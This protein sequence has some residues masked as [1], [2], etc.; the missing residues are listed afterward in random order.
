MTISMVIFKSERKNIFST[1]LEGMFLCGGVAKI[2]CF[3]KGCC[4]GTKTTLPWSISYPE[5]GLYNLHPVQLYE[6]IVLWI[7]FILLVEM[8]NKVGE[9]EKASIVILFYVLIRMFLLEGLYQGGQFLGSTK[10]R[11]LYGTVIII[12]CILLIVEDKKKGKE[13]N[14]KRK[15]E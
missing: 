2:G 9:I 14:E 11:L 5:H 15:K 12:C 3:I 8:N 6:A 1:I 13:K 10:M 7:G 4:I